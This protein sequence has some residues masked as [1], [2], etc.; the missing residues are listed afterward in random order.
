MITDDEAEKAVDYLRSNARAAA[1]A[2][3]NR[4]YMEE[5]RKVVK[6]QIMREQG[7]MPIT[8]QETV[9]YADPRYIQHLKAL[10]EAVEKDEYMR[11]MLAAA[12]AKIAAWQTQSA[13]TRAVERIR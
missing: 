3:A 5:Y 10:Q 9:A 8:A 7:A 12:E 4:V 1:Q 2:K 13:N 6:S 11:W